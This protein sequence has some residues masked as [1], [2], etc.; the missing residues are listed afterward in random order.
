MSLESKLIKLAVDNNKSA[1]EVV[2]KYYE[3]LEYQS[4]FHQKYFIGRE[5]HLKLLA[6]KNVEA[7]YK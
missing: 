7:C 1:T 4:R 3:M 6:Y 5:S 2:I